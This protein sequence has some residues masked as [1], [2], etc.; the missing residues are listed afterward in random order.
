MS[1]WTGV[2]VRSSMSLF[3]SPA[4][5]RQFRLKRFLSRWASSTTM[6]S[7]GRAW[8]ARRWGSRFAV[9]MDAMR[10]GLRSQSRTDRRTAKGKANFVSISSRHWPVSAAGVRTRTRWMSPRTAYSLRTSPAS[11]VLPRPTSSA[12]IARPRKSRKTR[13]AVRSWCS[14]RATPCRTGHARRRSNPSTREIRWAS[15]FKRHARGPSPGDPNARAR[16]S[17]SESSNRKGSEVSAEGGGSLAGRDMGGIPSP[18]TAGEPKV[19]SAVITVWLTTTR[20]RRRCD[21]G[22]RGGDGWAGVSARSPSPEQRRQD[23]ERVDACEPQVRRLDPLREEHPVRIRD[24]GGVPGR[25]DLRDEDVRH[26]EGRDENRE[27]QANR[28]SDVEEGRSEPRCDPASL[29][30]DG[31]HDRADVRPCEEREACAEEQH[32][33]NEMRIRSRRVRRRE[34]EERQADHGQAGRPQG[35]PPVLLRQAAAQRSRRERGDV[36]RD[37]QEARGQRALLQHELEVEAQEEQDRAERDRIQEL[38]DDAAG[39]LADAEELEIEQGV[40]VP[41]FEDH[42]QSETDKVHDKQHRHGPGLGDAVRREG[43]GEDK[44]Q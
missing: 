42:E 20:V 9:S 15:P 22:V 30:R 43:E 25:D 3:E 27:V 8:A 36:Q 12:R 19:A 34:P 35:Q 21:L 40:R 5:K 11:I 33:D 31:P 14:Y 16:R 10:K 38:G 1:F 39:E 18:A 26:A 32:V 29:G 6:R 4:T 41:P 24:R 13:S 28:V 23:R 37:H 2:A 17:R 44:A 7:H